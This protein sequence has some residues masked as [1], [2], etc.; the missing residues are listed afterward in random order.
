M[1]R[2]AAG[3]TA[4]TFNP[5]RG[6]PTRFAP[7][8]S[9]MPASLGQCIPTLYAGRTFEGAVF[10]SV[11][12]DLPPLPRKR[13]VFERDWRGAE[14]AKLTLLR[15]LQ[16]VK[17]FTQELAT[18]GLSRRLLVDCH[19]VDAYRWTVT[20][21]AAFHRD[22]TAASG[23]TWQSR[24]QDSEQVYMF[25]DGRADQACFRVDTPMP[26]DTGPGRARLEAMANTYKI[27][28]VPMPP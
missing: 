7:L 8:H 17:L 13:R 6:A 25:F 27:D 15:P 14:V 5:C 4:A 10:E 3:R 28:V 1:F 24:Q 16:A 9:V 21:A 20:W 19:G 23:L 18:V 26:L 11:L 2:P 22:N 12:R